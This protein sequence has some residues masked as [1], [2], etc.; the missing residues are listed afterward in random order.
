LEEQRSQVAWSCAPPVDPPAYAWWNLTVPA[1]GLVNLSNLTFDFGPA[2]GVLPPIDW[3]VMVVDSGPTNE[4]LHV[5]SAL[6]V[7]P[8]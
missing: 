4:T 1:A 3:E 5:D 2:P 8:A 7:A 6:T